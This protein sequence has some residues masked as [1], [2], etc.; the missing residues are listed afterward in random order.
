MRRALEQYGFKVVEASS[1][2]DALA[3]LEEIQGGVHLV[4]CDLVMPLMS[5][6]ALGRRINARWPALPILY[7]SGFPGADG[8]EE[9]MMPSGA[10][11]LKK[12]FTPDVLA[13][14]VRSMLGGS[15][16]TG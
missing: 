4:V 8:V 1:G 6:E 11:F 7:V 9:G 13:T 10:P 14:R 5:G 15:D 12:P 2:P 16:S 3:R